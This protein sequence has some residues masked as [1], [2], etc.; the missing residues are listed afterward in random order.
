MCVCVCV[1][2]CVCVCVCVC[3][4]LCV[5]MCVC[6]FVSCLFVGAPQLKTPRFTQWW[7]RKKRVK[8]FPTLAGTV[9]HTSA[10]HPPLWQLRS[11]F[12]D[13]NDGI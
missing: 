6:V 10:A 12:G 1:C 9:I 4:C 13:F 2:A 3:V 8:H 5:Y 11:V 7:V